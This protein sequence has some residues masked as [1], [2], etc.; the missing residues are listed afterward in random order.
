MHHWIAVRAYYKRGETDIGHFFSDD[1]MEEEL[2][3]YLRENVEYMEDLSSHDI[4]E[5]TKYT[6]PPP[7]IE[8]DEET[9]R[10]NEPTE[11]TDGDDSSNDSDDKEGES[12]I[13]GLNLDQLISY[14]I[15]VGHKC[16]H[17]QGGWG[18]VY[19]IKVDGR[20]TQY[21]TEYCGFD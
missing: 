8:E 2:R 1:S 5:V 15:A 19:V 17:H 13:G 10:G 12:I 18:L 20:S 7:R 21:G 9:T 6:H 16:I 11:Y 3:D 4:A 14:A